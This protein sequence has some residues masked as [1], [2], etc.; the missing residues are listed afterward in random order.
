MG[1]QSFFRWLQSHSFNF[2][3]AFR[4]YVAISRISTLNLMRGHFAQ[5][6][7]S[8]PAMLTV[9]DEQRPKEVQFGG[10]DSTTPRVRKVSWFLRGPDT[11]R[12]PRGC[13]AISRI[14]K[15]KT[16]KTQKNEKHMCWDGNVGWESAIPWGETW[17]PGG[18]WNSVVEVFF[19]R[20]KKKAGVSWLLR[21]KHCRKNRWGLKC[22]VGKGSWSASD[23][24][25]FR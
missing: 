17:V 18:C 16:G 7:V 2:P 12:F 15:N 23:Q 4:I 25:K 19:G 3:R 22:W 20:K 1:N 24:K 13:H 5:T 10:L 21:P 14:C 6:R 11:S 9:E 8:F